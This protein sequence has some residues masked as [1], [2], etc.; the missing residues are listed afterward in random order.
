MHLKQNLYAWFFFN[1]TPDR[2]MTSISVVKRSP[3]KTNGREDALLATPNCERATH[4]NR[5]TLA[6]TAWSR[7][8]QSGNDAQDN[9][10][11]A[12]SFK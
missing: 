8:C 7:F 11:N 2:L 3:K 9:E 12:A 10:G 1:L 6:S 5:A 4:L